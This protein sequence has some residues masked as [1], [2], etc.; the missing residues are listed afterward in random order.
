[1]EKGKHKGK[2]INIYEIITKTSRITF[3][4]IIVS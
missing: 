3:D 2:Y 1:M 4:R